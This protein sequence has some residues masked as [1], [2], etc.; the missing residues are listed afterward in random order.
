MEGTIRTFVESRVFALFATSFFVISAILFVYTA[1][2]KAR[3]YIITRI[4]PAVSI[5][6]S[7]L[8]RSNHIETIRILDF[9]ALSSAFGASW[10]VAISAGTFD[11]VQLDGADYLPILLSLG[12]TCVTALNTIRNINQG[13][14]CCLFICIAMLIASVKNTFFT[15]K[16]CSRD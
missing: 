11:H 10:A 7:V 16:I 12:S 13:T 14:L 8:S 1:Y 5:V 6:M 15:G 2:R 9:L 4:A 3:R